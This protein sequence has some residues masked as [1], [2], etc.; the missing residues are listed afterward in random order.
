MEQVSH[1]QEELE[2][3]FEHACYDGNSHLV[4]SFLKK[5]NP[6]CRRNTP[7]LWAVINNHTQIA[8]LLLSDKRLNTDGC[9]RDA[10][11]DAKERNNEEMFRLLAKHQN[12][13]EKQKKTN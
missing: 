7:I 13:F 5:V 3:L 10:I 12:D 4:E 8:K 6:S 9:Y 2:S 1:S 11:D